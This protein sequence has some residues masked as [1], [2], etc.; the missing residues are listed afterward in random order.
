MVRLPPRSTL[1]PYTT[2]FRSVAENAKLDAV[3]LEK[4]IAYIVSDSRRATQILLWCQD[5][6][7]RPWP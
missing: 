4:E 7:E 2:L 3:D 6:N 5:K 1:F